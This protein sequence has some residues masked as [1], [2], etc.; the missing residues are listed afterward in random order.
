MAVNVLVATPHAAF[1]EL[2]RLSLEDSGKYRVQIVGTAGDVQA[3]PG[4]RAVILDCD[5]KGEESAELAARLQK[6]LPDLKLIWIPLNNDPQSP[7]VQGLP[8]DGIVKRPFYL[9]DLLEMMDHLLGG[10][11]PT[12]CP[13]ASA[14]LAPTQGEPVGELPAWLDQGVLLNLLS[15]SDAQGALAVARGGCYAFGGMLPPAAADE[16]AD[17]VQNYWKKGSPADLVRFVRLVAGSSDYLFYITPVKQD[18][19]LG[20]VYPAGTALSK[21]RGQAGQMAQTLLA[22]GEPAQ[23]LTP[24]STPLHPADPTELANE[25]EEWVREEDLQQVNLSALLGSVPSPDP[26]QDELIPASSWIPEAQPFNSKGLRAVLPWEREDQPLEKV[27][28]PYAPEP[29]S[30]AVA[31]EATRPTVMMEPEPPAMIQIAPVESAPA[32]QPDALTVQPAAVAMPPEPAVNEVEDTR[33]R[34][35]STL[36]RLNQLEPASAALSLLNYTCVLIP[37]LPNHYLTRELAEK[38]SPWVQ[39]VC[40]AF[41]WRLDGLTIRPDFLEWT[42][43]VAPSISP[44]NMVRIVRQRTSQYIFAAFTHL[45]DENPSGDFWAVGYLIVSGSQP[46][47]AQLLRDFINQTRRRQGIVRPPADSSIR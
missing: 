23:T 4:L 26:S 28:P 7:A 21:I 3:L 44:G 34:V 2:L 36:T 11:P 5:L 24:I 38:L 12:R 39:Q 37:R 43:Q 1:G 35:L 25:G 8:V 9:P 41:G 32:A 27:E 30:A 29:L 14:A 31:N 15:D 45:Q 33:P 22:M 18:L 17:V 46:P 10:P 16:L 20:V 19:A 13:P 6:N 40:L 47:S 42:V